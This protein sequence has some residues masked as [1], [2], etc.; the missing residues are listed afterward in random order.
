MA[1]LQCC[2][3]TECVRN[4]WNQSL[5]WEQE[6]QDHGDAESQFD[7]KTEP[8]TAQGFQILYFGQGEFL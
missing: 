1:E 5:S 3:V 2:G 4:H 6:Q 8:D 7:T